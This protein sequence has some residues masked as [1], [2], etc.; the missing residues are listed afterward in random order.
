VIV[1][2]GGIT[3]AG[4]LLEAARAGLKPLLVEAGDFASGTSSRSGRLIHGGIRYLRD[5]HYRISYQ[6]VRERQRLLAEMPGLVMPAPVSYLC[7][8]SDRSPCWRLGAD[9]LLYELFAGS[10]GLEWSDANATREM[11]PLMLSRDVRGSYAYREGLTDDSRLVMRVIADALRFGATC[12]NYT[13]AIR[14]LRRRE[15][16]VC[17]VVVEDQQPG[18]KGRTLELNA[19]VVVNATGY[20]ADKLRAQ[21]GGASR[22]RMARGSHLNFPWE[23]FPVR[24]GLCYYHPRDQ[25]IQF[26]MPWR[27]AVIAG[28]T[29][30]DHDVTNEGEFGEPAISEEEVDYILEGLRHVFPQVRLERSDVLSTYSGVRPIIR[31]GAKSPSKESRRHAVWDESGLITIAGGKLT[32]Y[33]LMAQDAMKQAWRHLAG[34]FAPV[35]ASPHV[36]PLDL[37]HVQA[38]EHLG[39]SMVLELEGRY[40][41]DAPEVIRAAQ[42]GDLE[43]VGHSRTLW[44]ELRWAAMMER[45]VHLDD[46]LLRRVRLGLLLPEGGLALLERIRAVVQAELGWEEGRWRTEIEAYR[47]IWQRRYSLPV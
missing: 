32:T 40:G 5:H 13:R 20:L 41:Q 35:P 8:D 10:W 38:D 31:G 37:E 22:I 39:A 12:R 9:I 21:V 25:R 29:D 27:G 15:G 6:G 4:V 46:L 16:T 17:G 18:H 14:V 47:R 7:L 24:K 44:V 2:G 42:P 26:V 43:E 11:E 23:R 45:V 3:G 28:T 1:V 34:G 30:L 33:R 19:R 36:H